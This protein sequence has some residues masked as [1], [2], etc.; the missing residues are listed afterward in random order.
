MSY[1]AKNLLTKKPR[2]QK[3][4]LESFLDR[5]WLRWVSL[6]EAEPTDASSSSIPIILH[7]LSSRAGV[8][9]VVRLS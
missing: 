2:L 1:R 3:S 5:R 9:T 6:G 7:S 8:A 4:V